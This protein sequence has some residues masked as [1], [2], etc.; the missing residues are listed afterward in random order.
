MD[1]YTYFNYST[2]KLEE[3]AH[4]SKTRHA[5]NENQNN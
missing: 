3:I 4:M 2:F 1:L 5:I